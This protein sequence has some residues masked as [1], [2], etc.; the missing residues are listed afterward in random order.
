MI[1]N[2]AKISVII[3]VYN[4]EKYLPFAMQSCIEQTLYDVEFICINDGSTDG[5]LAILNEYA[6]KDERI[7]VIDMPN[8]GVSKARNE[9]LKRAT[10]K[11][12]MFLD[13]DDHL[14]K[15][16]CERAWIETEEGKTDIVIFGTEIIPKQPRPLPWHY[17]A[18]EVPTRRYYE[19]TPHVLFGE[20]SAKPF[21]WHQAYS[22]KLLEKSGV[23]FCEDLKLGEDMVFLMSLYPHA[24]NFAFIQDKLYYYRHTRKNSAMQSFAK[25]R[26]K[27]MKQ[28]L[29]VVEKILEHWAEN[30]YIKIC[31]AQYFDWALDFIL[32]ELEQVEYTREE[33]KALAE[34]LNGIFEKY[35]LFKFQ[36]S[37]PKRGRAYIKEL[38]ALLKG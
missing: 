27:K 3:P 37:L 23:C 17:Y 29:L 32:H 22:K 9:G 12:I 11:Y 30:D 38:K 4:V 1:N 34:K 28:H 6:S 16:A 24:S 31:G 8:G 7:T 35:Q 36:N 33:K 18:L 26:L 21:I 10:G 14:D 20:P 25:D 5:S 15:K 2:P 19:F 13:P